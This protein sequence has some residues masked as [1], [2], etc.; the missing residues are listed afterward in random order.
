MIRTVV[1]AHNE[2]SRLFMHFGLWGFSGG[3]T[4]SAVVSG[5]FIAL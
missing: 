4:Q 1:V 2:L 3:A 5:F